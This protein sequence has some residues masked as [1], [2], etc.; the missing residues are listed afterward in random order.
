MTGLA[1]HDQTFDGPVTGRRWKI[2]RPFVE[3]DW[4]VT[5]SLT[6]NLGLAWDMTTPITEAHGRLANY[7]PA[8]GQLLIAGQNGVSASAGVKMDWTALE[9]RIG[10]AWKV[11]GSDKTVLRAG[12]AIYP[13]FGLEPGRAGPMA[14]SALPR[15][16]RCIRH[17][18]AAH[19]RP[20]TALP[21]S[22]RTPSGHQPFQRLPGHPAPPT[23][24]TLPA[25]SIRSPPTSSSAECSNTT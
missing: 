23:A 2:Y 3:D 16:I 4:R 9:P 21:C 11:C 20:P 17:L 13:R 19:F 6:L 24:D 12:F 18:Q 1:I 7:V 5:S 8:T 14:E 22:D 25:R 15:R 10:A